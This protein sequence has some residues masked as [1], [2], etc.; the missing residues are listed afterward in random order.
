MRHFSILIGVLLLSANLW[1]SDQGELEMYAEDVPQ[2]SIP[3]MPISVEQVSMSA[4]DWSTPFEAPLYFSDTVQIE[5][6][7][8]QRLGMVHSPG[9]ECQ[10]LEGTIATEMSVTLY[11]T[12]P[13]TDIRDP[14]NVLMHVTGAIS[15]D[16]EVN[17][18]FEPYCAFAPFILHDDHIA[19]AEGIVPHAFL[20]LDTLLKTYNPDLEGLFSEL[21]ESMNGVG[22]NPELD[23]V[24]LHENEDVQST[25]HTS[26]AA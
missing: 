14:K 15:K 6:H 4:L 5:G 23:D 11:Y 12:R 7:Y 13:G 8:Y 16:E 17:D 3:L 20:D 26:S 22:T 1:A 10:D 9:L 19:E 25:H 2:D 24:S 18:D 21:Y